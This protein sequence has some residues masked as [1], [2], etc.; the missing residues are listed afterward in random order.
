MSDQ[1]E[2]PKDDSDVAA[3]TR[4]WSAVIVGLCI[5]GAIASCMFGGPRP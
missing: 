2:P 3:S 1:D 4:F 5:L